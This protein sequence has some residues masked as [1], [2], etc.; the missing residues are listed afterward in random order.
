MTD[1]RDALK[2]YADAWAALTPE[3]VEPLRAV[4]AETVRF[5][6]PFN[7]ITG[8]DAVLSSLAE[9]Y[10]RFQSVSVTVHDQAIGATA[11]Y[12]RWTYIFTTRR[13]R[14]FAIEGMSEMRFDGT[15]RALLHHDHWDAA[16]QIYEKVP[17]LGGV[18]RL[19]RRRV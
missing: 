16:G 1:T 15:G 10:R 13:G 9:S 18:L 19:I 3:D 17:V 6:D 14:R 8:K 12:L 7:D 11:A 4:L 5:V 2:R